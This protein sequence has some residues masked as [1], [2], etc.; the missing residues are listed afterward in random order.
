MSRYAQLACMDCK[1]LCFPGKAVYRQDER[2]DYFKIGPASEP[3]NWQRPELNRVIWKMLADHAGHHLQVVVSGDAEFEQAAD[4]AMIGGVTGTQE[5]SFEDYL[6][7]W[8]GGTST[9]EKSQGKDAEK[10]TT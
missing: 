5:I 7:D 9:L 3:A 10:D 2:I 8:D 1:V 4:F 6:T